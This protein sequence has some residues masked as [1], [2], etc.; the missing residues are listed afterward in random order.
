MALCPLSRQPGGA[1]SNTRRREEEDEGE[2][3][4]TEV[5]GGHKEVSLPG[6]E[7]PGEKKRGDVSVSS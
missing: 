2:A 4:Q 3:V 5:W 6:N 1:L 7:T